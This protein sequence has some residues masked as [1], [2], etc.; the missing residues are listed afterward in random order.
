MPIY[1]RTGN[2]I[3][4]TDSQVQGSGS[5]WEKETR[6][7]DAQKGDIGC[8][9]PS[10]SSQGFRHAARRRPGRKQPGTQNQK[11]QIGRR[12]WWWVRWRWGCQKGV[13]ETDCG[14]GVPGLDFTDRFAFVS[15]VQVLHNVQSEVFAGWNH[16]SRW[17]E[18]YRPQHALF[19]AVTAL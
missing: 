14:R 2:D 7:I 19:S 11:E 8:Q 9:K 3:L 10:Y 17:F 12:W 16:S 13:G 6:N 5:G 18:K 4:E 1:R 15:P